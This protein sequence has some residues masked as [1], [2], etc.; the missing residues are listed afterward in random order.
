MPDYEPGTIE[1]LEQGGPGD[2]YFAALMRFADADREQRAEEEANPPSEEELRKRVF[3]HGA[4]LS[5]GI[6]GANQEM[7][8][9]ALV[10]YLDAQFALL[11]RQIEAK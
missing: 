3:E 9:T 4:E 10:K 2:R 11:K 8:F 1:S 6:I 5:G 7:A